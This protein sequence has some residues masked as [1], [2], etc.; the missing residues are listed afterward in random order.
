ME[1]REFSNKIED[2]KQFLTEFCEEF[3]EKCE[4]D[5]SV[6]LR[7]TNPRI[8]PQELEGECLEWCRDFLSTRGCPIGFSAL[9]AHE[10][11][12]RVASESLENFY[13]EDDKNEV[14]RIDANQGENGEEIDNKDTDDE[15]TEYCAEKLHDHV[16][17]ILE[18]VCRKWQADFPEIQI[19]GKLPVVSFCCIKNT[20]RKME[21]KH[22]II[23]DLNALFGLKGHPPQSFYGV[24]DGHAG[25]E[26]AL[27]AAKHIHGNLV[28]HCDLDKDPVEACKASFKVTDEQYIPKAKKV[29]WRSG[30]TAVTALVRGNKLYLSWLGDSQASLVK[31]GKVVTRMEPH[32][33]DRQDERDRIEGLGGLVVL[34]GDLWRVGGNLAVS[35]AIGDVGYKPFISSDAEVLEIELDGTEEYMVLAC[36][37]LWDVVTE[38]E[39]PQLVFNFLLESNNDRHG[40]AKYLVQYAKDRES[41]DNISVIV[42]FFR[43]TVTEPVADAGFF[44]F[45]AGDS[46]GS[47]GSGGN[48]DSNSGGDNSN[49]SNRRGGNSNGLQQQ[50][51]LSGGNISGQQRLFVFSPEDE[52]GWNG[53]FDTSGNNVAEE[54]SESSDTH[55]NEA[56][57]KDI[58]GLRPLNLTNPEIMVDISTDGVWDRDNNAQSKQRS[59]DVFTETVEHKDTNQVKSPYKEEDLDSY[60]VFNTRLVDGPID[61]SIIDDQNSSYLLKDI[62]DSVYNNT[63]GRK[64]E[65][66]YQGKN[67]ENYIKLP[68]LHHGEQELSAR[69]NRKKVKKVKSEGVRTRRDPRKKGQAS[70]P[71]CWAFTGKNQASV[72]NHRLNMAA[73]ANKGS[74]PTPGELNLANKAPPRLADKSTHKFAQ[75]YSS[76]ENVHEI[77]NMTLSHGKLESLPPP[78][79][80][81][82][83]NSLSNL[84]GF[85]VFGSKASLQTESQKFQT[86]LRTRKPLKPITSVVYETPPTPFVSNKLHWARQH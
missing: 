62:A 48:S 20:R 59:G 36:D 81:I 67:N 85:T 63:T 78:R 39:L 47:N 32:K 54:D 29:K 57:H 12:E 46:Q 8:T 13:I 42:V 56:Y 18:T 61:L 80:K 50:R 24:F 77:A 79:P 66:S 55:D 49:A 5:D 19:D 33:P 30:C 21:D 64:L 23:P 44:N 68:E 41:M 51:D 52:E 3:K 82:S 60:G 86:T 70:S 11:Y 38:E 37:G 9:I 73:K 71:V 40:V 45:L 83:S 34:M 75:V 58:S 28:H 1:Q 6:P 26:A 4:S 14:E 35:R 27:F 43:D 7:W 76:T 72:Q 65:N 84:S 74:H 31:N 22:V 25:I 2:F 16:I 10:V 69:H 17:S 53:Q 15:K